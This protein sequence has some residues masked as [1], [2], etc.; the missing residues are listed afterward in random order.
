MRRA[1]FVQKLTS[2]GMERWY[3][4]GSEFEDE[5]SDWQVLCVCGWSE[6]HVSF[7]SAHV[8]G[9]DHCCDAVRW[10]ETDRRQRAAREAG[11]LQVDAL[12]SRVREYQKHL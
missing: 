5:P 9:S 11:Q 8:S 12:A 1:V 3:R 7:E 2:R 4:N 6:F 10:R